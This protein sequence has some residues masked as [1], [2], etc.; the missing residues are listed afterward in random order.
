PAAAG[1]EDLP[2]PIRRTFEQRDVGSGR[3]RENGGHRSGRPGP[4]HCD[5]THPRLPKRTF[6]VRG[7]T[8]SPVTAMTPSLVIFDLA[9]TTIRDRGEVV[10]CFTVALHE[11]GIMFTPDELD[12]WRGASKRDVLHRLVARQNLP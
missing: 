3:C 10:G 5:S 9:G 4:D 11:C 7:V 8:I 6:R 2:A 12:H 1:Y